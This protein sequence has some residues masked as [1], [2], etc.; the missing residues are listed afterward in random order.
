LRCIPGGA[1]GILCAFGS[2]A[3][4]AFSFFAT[5]VVHLSRG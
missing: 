1:T 3:G 4:A 2:F 5:L